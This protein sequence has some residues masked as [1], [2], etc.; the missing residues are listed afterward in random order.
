M[1]ISIELDSILRKR[2]CTSKE[3]A[4]RIGITEANL[5]RLKTGK[6]RT[7]RFDLLN[8]LCRELKCAPGDILKYE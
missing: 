7:I 5:S 4:G 6:A 2:K 8:D 1:T 3:L